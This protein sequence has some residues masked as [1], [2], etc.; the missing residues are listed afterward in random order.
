MGAEVEARQ[1]SRED[2]TRHRE[3]VR[4]GLDALARMLTA[5]H[6][7][8]DRPMT[9]LE[10]ELNL[11]DDDMQPAM[12][13]AEVLEAIADPAFQTELGRFNIEINV[14]PRQLA[15][16]GFASFETSIR[17]ALNAAEDKVE[18]VGIHLAMV[19]IL[20]TL[21]PEH[22]TLE[23]VSENPRYSLL[24]QQ[25][26]AA[27]GEDLEIVIDGV[28]RLRMISDTIMPEADCTSTQ[29]HLQ[30]SPD[31]FAGY[32]NAA[33]AVAGVQVAVGANSPFL[34]GRELVAESRI[35]LFEQS[36]DTRAE[37]LKIQGVRPRVW[38]GERW[39]TSIFDLFEENSN[40][41]PAL[42]PISTDEDPIAVLD[43][44]GVPTLDEL[45]LHNGTVYRW[46]RPVYDISGGSPHLRVEN[47]VLPA[48]PTVVDT[49]ANAAFFAGLVRALA[50]Q[51]RPIWTQMSFQAANENFISGI[52][53][54]I[55]A[56]V[57]WPRIGQVKVAE[58][59]VRR[60]LPMAA[61][62]LAEWG[63]SDAESGRLLDVIE[64][65][66]LRA[67]NGA[68]WQTAVVSRREQAGESRPEALSGMLR[69]YLEL[70]HTN[71]PVHL[72]E[73][74]P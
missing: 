2:R 30:V 51:D 67:A 73:I 48:G 56:D 64:Q 46:N 29:V 24:D 43:D 15:E 6:F 18:A 57:Y 17:R 16:G 25:V 34:F 32:W 49:L 10:I 12:R 22:A 27:R 26:F 60:L 21:M 71:V 7:D 13:N 20:P 4:R 28:E 42:L 53:H 23:N 41:F 35:P 11:V 50:A 72:W 45:R 47:R 33:Q 44:G 61:E 55:N 3:K 52:R 39:I 62:G 1:F 68:T 19:G 66:C 36:T 54:G 70:M 63:V 5:S 58:L 9:G 31:E 8:A 37:E 65:R 14:A 69:T 74:A 38:F 59:V 40:Y